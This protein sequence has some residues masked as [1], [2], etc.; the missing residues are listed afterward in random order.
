MSVTSGKATACIDWEYAILFPHIGLKA[1]FLCFNHYSVTA[2]STEQ[3]TS[4]WLFFRLWNIFS[5][6]VSFFLSLLSE[7]LLSCQVHIYCFPGKCCSQSEE[8]HVKEMEGD[9]CWQF[10]TEVGV[11]TLLFPPWASVG[12]TQWW[13]AQ[14]KSIWAAGN[15]GTAPGSSC[16]CLCHPGTQPPA[17]ACALMLLLQKL[18]FVKV[19]LSCAEVFCKLIFSHWFAF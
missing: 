11:C 1:M 15:G 10:S 17:P 12:C 5:C 18:W 4:F 13:G 2:A 7:E 16:S 8:Y 6:T 3:V 19:F 14:W 9:I